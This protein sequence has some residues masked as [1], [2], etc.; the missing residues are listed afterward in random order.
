MLNHDKFDDFIKIKF[1]SLMK[2]ETMFIK[3]SRKEMN[4]LIVLYNVIG[5]KM[6]S[7]LY[8]EKPII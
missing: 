5:G 1:P 4:S 6:V 3:S 8:I 7:I 2:F